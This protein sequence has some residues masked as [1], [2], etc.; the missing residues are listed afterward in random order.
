MVGPYFVLSILMLKS[1][2][3]IFLKK[4]YLCVNKCKGNKMKYYKLTGWIDKGIRTPIY[5]FYTSKELALKDILNKSRPKVQIKD[6][7]KYNIYLSSNI[8][9]IKE[10]IINTE[11]SD[12]Y[13]TITEASNKD[14]KNFVNFQMLFKIKENIIYQDFS[15]YDGS[16]TKF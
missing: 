6:E 14:H 1:T 8:S 16:M 5:G 15:D 11:E 10:Y 12:T 4:Y 13:V 9:N 2:R 3:K 7:N